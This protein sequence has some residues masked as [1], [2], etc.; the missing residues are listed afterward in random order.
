MLSELE[1]SA[2]TGAFIGTRRTRLLNA[3]GRRF[4]AAA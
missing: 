3:V 4:K 2:D 1:P